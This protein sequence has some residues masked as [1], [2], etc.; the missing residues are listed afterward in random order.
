MS[1]RAG[2]LLA[3]GLVSSW[4]RKQKELCSDLPKKSA[5]FKCD[6][7]PSEREAQRRKEAED[8]HSSCLQA[9]IIANGG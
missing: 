8:A 5:L 9:R 1:Y 4:K 7:L 6:L 3:P 2:T